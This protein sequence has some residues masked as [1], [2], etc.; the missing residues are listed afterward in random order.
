MGYVQEDSCLNCEMF[1]TRY[2]DGCQHE[3]EMRAE[4]EQALEDAYFQFESTTDV[5]S[6]TT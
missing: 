6:I 1:G 4:V 2:C 5:L 3:E